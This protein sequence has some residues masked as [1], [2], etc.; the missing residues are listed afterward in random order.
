MSFATKD[1]KAL[2]I[3]MDTLSLPQSGPVKSLPV[4]MPADGDA[5]S[6][7]CCTSPG[8]RVT[9]VPLFGP[10]AAA[11]HASGSLTPNHK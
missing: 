6:L 11:P 1:L 5:Q 7:N 8:V 2:V 9:N 10:G 4:L 3:T